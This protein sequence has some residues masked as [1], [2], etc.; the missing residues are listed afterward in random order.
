MKR[1]RPTEDSAVT[2]VPLWDVFA[3]V[4]INAMM[5]VEYWQYGEH[6]LDDEKMTELVK[7]L[8]TQLS[9]MA[10]TCM[11]YESLLR[12]AMTE[13]PPGFA[14]IR[15]KNPLYNGDVT[16]P[17]LNDDGEIDDLDGELPF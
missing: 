5:I 6:G 2:N 17:L 16:S 8:D 9:V 3:S 14:A 13:I 4:G 11:E 1:Q 7:T 10:N 12:I 15:M